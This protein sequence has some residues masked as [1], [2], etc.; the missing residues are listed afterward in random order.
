MDGRRHRLA[1]GLLED[2]GLVG[3]DGPIVLEPAPEPLSDEVLGAVFA[4][5]FVRAMRK[6]SE[7]PALASALEARQ[8]GIGGDNGAYRGMHEDS[9]RL[10][11]VAWRGGALVAHGE[12]S[13]VLLP[14]SGAHHG[15]ANRASGFGI[16]NETAVSIAAARAAGAERIAYVDLDVHHGDGTQWIFYEDPDVL[17]VSVHESGRHLFPGTGFPGETGGPGAPGSAANVPL[18]PFAGD[19]DWLAAVDEVVVPV[20]RRFRP[21]VIVAQCG[22]DHHHADPLSHHLTTLPLYPLLWERLDALSADLCDGRWLAH[23]GGGYAACGA[24]PRAWA[25]LG[26]RMTGREVTGPLPEAWRRR[27]AAEGCEDPPR[28]WLEDQHPDGPGD[29]E[30]TA[31]RLASRQSI[32]TARA[33]LTAAGALA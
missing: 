19:D 20:V 4:P 3:D 23:G 5:A 16:Y 11:G 9:A 1:V 32:D 12:P 24:A 13:R 29:D 10:A 22:V 2:A 33:A 25:L 28:G 30:R 18:P 6:Y 14:A 31:A 15:A 27:S 17:T 7:Q 21:D 26:A 8:W